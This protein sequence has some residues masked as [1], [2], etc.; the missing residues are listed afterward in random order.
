MALAALATDLVFER[1]SLYRALAPLRRAGLL[2]VHVGADQRAREVAL[3]PQGRRRVARAMPH[4]VAAQRSVLGG[5]GHANWRDLAAR[6]RHLTTIA[7][8]MAPP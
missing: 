8:A 3:T 5:I 4:W 1:T 7:G 6:L 2:A